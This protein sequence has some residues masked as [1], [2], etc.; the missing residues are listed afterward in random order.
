ME[1]L[2][3]HVDGF[4][5]MATEKLANGLWKSLYDSTIGLLSPPLV[6]RMCF[7]LYCENAELR[8]RVSQLEKSS[9]VDGKHVEHARVQHIGLE[10]R[11]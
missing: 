4:G 5:K 10:V 11:Q 8:E 7:R 1:D 6:A 9:K 2:D 3:K